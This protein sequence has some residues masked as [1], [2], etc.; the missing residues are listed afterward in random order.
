MSCMERS[1]FLFAHDCDQPGIA[2]CAQC[3]KAICALHQRESAGRIL[4]I[5]CFRADGAA[6]P[7]N[8]DPYFYAERHVPGW[9]RWDSADRAAF[10]R[11]SGSTVGVGD[12]LEPGVDAT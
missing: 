7:A 2:V 8:D 11:R 3:G 6:Q 9:Q 10:Q 5:A 1:G 12:D 4:C